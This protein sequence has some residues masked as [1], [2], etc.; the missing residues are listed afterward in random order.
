TLPLDWRTHYIKPIFKSKDRTS[1]L[2]YRPIALLPVIS[3]VLER[4][5]YN[6]LIVHTR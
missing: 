5:V 2:N 1:G 4:I 6:R 3:K